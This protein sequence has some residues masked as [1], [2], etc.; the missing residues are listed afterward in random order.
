MLPYYDKMRLHSNCFRAN[1]EKYLWTLSFLKTS[2]WLLLDFSIMHFSWFLQPNEPIETRFF[3]FEHVLSQFSKVMNIMNF[4]FRKPIS[5][6]RKKQP[7]CCC[8]HGTT[9]FF[10][11]NLS[12]I[13]QNLLLTKGINTTNW[14]HGTSINC[15]Y[16]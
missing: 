10:E 2:W 11:I 14:R 13:N 12:S 7:I 16:Y 3:I 6:V 9:H 4:L 5:F 1:F 15:L 8:M